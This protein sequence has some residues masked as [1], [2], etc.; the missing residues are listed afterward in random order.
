[1]KDL[2]AELERAEVGSRELDA[3]I[4]VATFDEFSPSGDLVYAKLPNRY[5]HCTAGTY[6]RKSRSG[7]SLYTAPH[8]TTSLD[9]ALTLMPEGWGGV[10]GLGCSGRTWLWKSNHTSSKEGAMAP[11]GKLPALNLCIAAL[12]A[13]E[14]EKSGP[15]E[16]QPGAGPP[17]RKLGS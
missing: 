8:Y 7:A 14:Q 6:W 17:N 15:A 11:T 16:V 1:M 4:A 5:D 12:K 10:L 9:A 3:K 13:I 2:I